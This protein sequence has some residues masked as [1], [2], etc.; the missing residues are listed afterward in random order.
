MKRNV[1]FLTSIFICILMVF[2]FNKSTCAAAKT[3]K[4]TSLKVANIDYSNYYSMRETG[5]LK[6]KTTFEPKNA[7]NK[8]LTWVS[9]DKT[10]AKV[11][12]KGFVTGLSQ[13]FCKIT[14]TTKDG[15]NKKVSFYVRVYAEKEFLL[16]GSWMYDSGNTTVG[17]SLSSSGGYTIWNVDGDEVD[18]GR[19]TLDL[20]KKTITLYH[21]NNS[22]KKVWKYTIQSRS[23]LIL[24]NGTTQNT[25]TRNYKNK[26]IL[27]TSKGLLYVPNGTTHADIIGYVGMDTTVTIPSMINKHEVTWVSGFSGNTAIEKIIIP[28]CV[29]SVNSFQ[30]CTNLKSLTI[31]YSVSYLSGSVFE[32]C[33]SLETVQLP[34]KLEYVQKRTFAGC[35]SLTSIELPEKVTGVDSEAFAECTNLKAL[36][37]PKEIKEIASDSLKGCNNVVIYGYK[38]TSAEDFAK[39]KNLTF[40]ER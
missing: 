19:Y 9:S 13:G 20:D 23:K 7:T 28:D 14:G 27:C 5:T 37:F 11:D 17:L 40:V 15:S 24:S 6:I 12:N 21:T 1:L 32:N 10:I 29:T 26:T 25:C 2:Y 31:P 39:A 38:N 30:D 36:I 8:N 35:T 3:V 16:N 33:T 4:V 22:T 18:S 34:A